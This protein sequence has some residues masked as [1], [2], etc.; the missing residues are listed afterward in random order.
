M[1]PKFELLL[2][3]C[4]ENGVVN[5]YRRAHKHTDNP[6][7]EYLCMAIEE[8]VMAEIY[9]WFDFSK[10]GIMDNECF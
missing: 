5:G 4:V 7:E 10:S 8:S 1:K 9:E 6:E 3:Y 2:R